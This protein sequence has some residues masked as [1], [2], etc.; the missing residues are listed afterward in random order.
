MENIKQ[1]VY[2][3]IEGRVSVQSF[4]AECERHPEILDW[5]QS[6]VPPELE[7]CELITVNGEPRLVPAP[8]NIRTILKIDEISFGRRGRLSFEYAVFGDIAKAVCLAFPD[9]PP[10]KDTALAVMFNNILE[11]CPSYIG[12]VEVEQDGIL[13][14]II[15]SIP[16]ELSKAAGKKWAKEKIKE[17]FHIQGRHYPYWI[18][19]PEWPVYQ[20][21]PMEYVRTVK[22]GVEGQT[23]YFRDPKTGVERTVE[24][25]H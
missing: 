16:A 5:I 21:E 17:R 12:G 1:Y 19:E 15:H 11:C 2:D 6:I 9:S 13:E 8:Y 14:E 7:G 23:H 22:H 20:G 25:W 10:H 24:D 18:Q 4:L 3:L